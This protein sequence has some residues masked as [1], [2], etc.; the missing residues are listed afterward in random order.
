[1]PL[2]PT[3]GTWSFSKAWPWSSPRSDLA[4]PNLTG[5][6]TLILRTVTSCITNT[7]FQ[8]FTGTQAGRAGTP[9]K[10]SQR[11]VDCFMRLYFK[12]PV[13][14]FFTSPISSLRTLATRTS[15]YFSTR[16]PLSHIL[17]FSPSRKTPQAKRHGAWFYASFEVS[18]AAPLFTVLRRSHFAQYTFTL[19]SPKKGEA[20]TDFLQ[21]LYG[22]MQQHNVDF[23]GGDFNMSAFST[24]GDVFSDPEFSALGNSFLWGLGALEEP[25]RECTGILIMPKR[26]YEWRV[27]SHGCYKF[28]NAAR[29]LRTS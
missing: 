15:P 21:Q 3:C 11:L 29:G 19:S 6:D 2:V 23:I 10:T 7:V 17:R 8:F 25:N 4:K 27:D 14:K 22:H 1:M 18:C 20:S 9:P 5:S 26:P 13:I 16:I 28:D 24:G 12:K